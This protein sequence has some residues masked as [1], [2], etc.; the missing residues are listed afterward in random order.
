MNLRA[1]YQKVRATEQS[2]AE[3]YPVVVSAETPDGGKAGLRNEVGREVAAK[4]IVEG[5]ARLATEGESREF[6]DEKAEAKRLADGAA[7]AARV[8][9]TVVSDSEMKALRGAVNKK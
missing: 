4:M 3:E 7:A 2:I 5:R 6:R 1:Y 9:V 8:Q